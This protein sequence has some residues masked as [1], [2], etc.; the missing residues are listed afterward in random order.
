MSN[1][2]KREKM[3]KSFP[4]SFNRDGRERG[5]HFDLIFKNGKKVKILLFSNRCGKSSNLNSREK[6]VCTKCSSDGH[7]LIFFIGV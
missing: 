2:K 1:E 3:E 7:R 5:S 4:G 6:V